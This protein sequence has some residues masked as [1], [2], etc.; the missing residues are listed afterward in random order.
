MGMA[1]GIMSNLSCSRWPAS[2]GID[3]PNCQA[4]TSLT[5]FG[6]LP[7]ITYGDGG[8]AGSGEGISVWFT[9]LE[10]TAWTPMSFPCTSYSGSFTGK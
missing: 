6:G 2:T 1:A 4:L 10:S 7:P 3:C 5:T 8:T 9:R